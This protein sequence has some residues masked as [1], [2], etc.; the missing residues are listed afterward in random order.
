[1]TTDPADQNAA[2]IAEWNGEVGLR[3]AA[4][5][6]ALDELIRPFGEAALAA[7]A[8]S[9]GE[10]ALDIGCGC[11][12]TSLDLAA[13]V[14]PGGRV[15]G[16]DISQ[17]MLDV[18]R[19]RAAGLPHVAFLLGDASRVALPER[20]S[21]VFSRFGV[22][23]FDAPANAFAH[24]GKGLEAGGRLAF[25]CWQSAPLNPWAS[26]PA[27]A[28]RQAAGLPA[29]P[30]EPHKP[31]PFAFADPDH[32]HAVLTSAGFVNIAISPFEAPMKLGG[33]VREAA[34][35][36]LRVGPAGRV[37]REAGPE[38]LPA[39]IDGVESALAPFAASDGSVLLPGRV[40]IVTARPAG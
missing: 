15:L 39:L 21:L 7:A 13:R 10:R 19:R 26:V 5:Q 36:A 11:G 14:G 18:A 12:A 16:L 24:L 31:G 28:A 8:P 38:R 25:V 34:E 37:A 27:M 3:W 35:Q 6:A 1:M 22:M 2:Q 4:E 32:V 29:P 30:P 17:P 33:S 23:F 9:P 20:Y 40:W